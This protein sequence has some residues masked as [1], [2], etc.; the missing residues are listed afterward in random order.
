M[1]GGGGG[2]SPSINRPIEGESCENLV[3]NVNIASPQPDVIITLSRG[4]ILNVSAVSDQGPIQV[5]TQDG[6]LAG[7]V[8]SRDQVRLMNC[9]NGGVTYI[10]EVTSIDGGQCGVQIRHA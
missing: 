10:A 2:S 1:S 4:N 3:L 5:I 8:I 6:R 7:N 9:I